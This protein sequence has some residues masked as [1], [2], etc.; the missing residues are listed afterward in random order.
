MDVTV[1]LPMIGL[2]K[3]GLDGVPDLLQSR[4]PI[5]TRRQ[6]Q[7]CHLFVSLTFHFG[8]PILLPL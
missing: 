8:C 2:L 7:R 4:L 3:T 5:D 1:D 6:E